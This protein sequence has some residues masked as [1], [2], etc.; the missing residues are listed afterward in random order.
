[1][2]A[3]VVDVSRSSLQYKLLIVPGVTV[4]DTATANNI[5]RFVADGGT[6]IM[7]ANSALVDESGQVF[8]TTHPGRLSDVFGIR[9]GSYEETAMLN[10]I[11]RVG[12]TGKKIEVNYKGENIISTS[13]RLDVIETKGAQVLGSITSLDKDYP[14]IT[15]NTYGKGTAIY[16]GLAANAAILNPLLDHLINKLNIKKG[17]DVPDSVMA[18]KIDKNHFLYLNISSKPKEIQINARAHSILFDKD[19]KGSFILAPEEPEFIEIK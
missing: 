15:S 17:P 18:R 14:I 1:M 2:D 9:V 19:Y 8:S 5:R 13:D 6:V 3:R 7:T 12:Y 10:E 11:S 4:M 16:V